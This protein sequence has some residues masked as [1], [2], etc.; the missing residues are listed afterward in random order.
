MLRMTAGGIEKMQKGEGEEKVR[1]EEAPGS[2]LLEES[3]DQTNNPDQQEEECIER[4]GR[5][6]LLRQQTTSVWARLKKVEW[7]A[8]ELQLNLFPSHPAIASQVDCLA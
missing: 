3:E 7:S 5:S 6:T 8:D 2:I 4:Q 1:E